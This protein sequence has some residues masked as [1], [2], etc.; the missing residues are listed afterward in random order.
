MKLAATQPCSALSSRLP[1]VRSYAAR[2]PPQKALPHPVTSTA[3]VSATAGTSQ[4][5]Q[6]PAACCLLPPASPAAPPP[7]PGAPLPPPAALPLRPL[8]STPCSPRRTT[9]TEAP[10]AP[11]ASSSM[12]AVSS[13]LACPTMDAASPSLGEKMSHTFSRASTCSLVAGCSAAV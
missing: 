6:A 5:S 7:A 10:P 3:R 13:G 12:S 8:T 1:L 2:K 4:A 9:T 11:A